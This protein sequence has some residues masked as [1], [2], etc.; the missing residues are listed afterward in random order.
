MGAQ[1]QPLAAEHLEELSSF[2]SGTFGDSAHAPL[3]QPDM[4]QWKYLDPAGFELPR[5]LV[6]VEGGRIAGHLGMHVTAFGDAIAMHPC[7]WA[8]GRS[9]SPHGLG[10]L[11]RAHRMT[12][13]QYVMGCT[14]AAAQ[15]FQRIGYAVPAVIPLFQKIVAPMA[16][17]HMH[18][19]QPLW[20][21]ATL[22]AV[23]RSRSRLTVR[24]APT[25][26]VEL[27]QVARFGADVAEIVARGPAVIASSRAPELLNHYLRF[28][29]GTTRGWYVYHESRLRGFALANVVERGPVRLGKVLDCYLDS[30]DPGLWH[31]AVFAMVR[32]LAAQDCHHVAAYGSAPWV[33]A[34]LRSN[35]FFERGRTPLYWRDV[36]SRVTLDKPLHLTYLEADNGY[37]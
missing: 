15:V 27:K 7:D 20:K 6:V 24:R 19:N 33:A 26:C 34:A 31:A 18:R 28:P 36:K 9:R 11:L 30:D 2:L 5:S 16:W 3:F 8:A 37:L 21:R 10:L 1:I 14:D 29:P 17:R 13:T 25:R 12:D 22:L 23:D 35:G 32:E 4:L